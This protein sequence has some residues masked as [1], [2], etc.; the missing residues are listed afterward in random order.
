M[1]DTSVIEV[2]ELKER[3]CG[4]TKTMIRVLDSFVDTS[5]TYRIKL[6]SDAVANDLA[7]LAK[8]LHTIKGLLREI[9]AVEGAKALEDL[10]HKLKRQAAFSPEDISTVQGWIDSASEAAVLTKQR[11]QE[12]GPAV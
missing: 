5:Q 11:L 9:S 2:D 10:E 3:C 12:D 8:T 6:Q 7:T 4:Q 1:E